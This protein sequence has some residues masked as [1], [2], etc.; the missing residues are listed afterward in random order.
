MAYAVRWQ[1]NFV[2]RN[3]DSYRL[4][5]LQD[6]WSGSITYLRGAEKPI[7]TSEDNSDDIFTPIRKQ[8]GALRIADNGFDIN[9]NAFDYTDLIPTDTFDNQVRL[10]L[11]GQTDTLRW[12]GY[13]RP[14]SLTSR[15][16]EYVSIREFQIVCPLGTLYEMPVSFS[17][18]KNDFGTIKT[19]GQ[20]LHAALS[21][22]GVAWGNVYK[23][24]NVQHR[25]DLIAKVSMLNFLSTN[26]PTHSTPSDVDTF[27]ATWQDESTSWGSVVEDVCRFWGWTLYSR[28][29][30]L[31][32][33]AQ[34]QAFKFAKFAFSNLT[35]TSNS[36]MS[37]ISDVD[38]SIDDLT[39][40]S[41]NHTESRK[42]GYKKIS[43]ESDVNEWSTVLDPDY[44]KATFSYYPNDSQVIHQS[45]DYM[46][47]LRRLGAAN[48]QQNTQTQFID[49]FQIYEN[50]VLQTSTL[51][52][53]FVIEYSDPMYNEDFPTKTAF[54]LKKG[55]VCYQGGQSGAITFFAKTLEDVIIPLNSAISINASAELSY[56]PDPTFPTNENFAAPYDEDDKPILEGRTIH[57]A[58]AIGDMWWDDAHQYW[59]GTPTAFSITMRK[60]GS[61]T[62]PLNT[63]QEGG[64]SPQGI[65]FDNHAGTSG[66]T[67][68][69]TPD[70]FT[71]NGLCGRLKLI[72]YATQGEPT[73]RLFNGVLNS[74][75]V[76]IYNQDNKLN[77][78]NK[79]SHTYDG[80]A[81]VN[82]RNSR[83]VSLKMASGAQNTY[84]KGQLYNG[85]FS[86]LTTVPFRS[87]GLYTSMS[88]EARLLQMMQDIYATVTEHDIIEIADNQNASLPIARMSGHWSGDDNFRPLCV[89]HDWVDGT[90]ELTIFNK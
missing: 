74:L 40:V 77:P 57:V 35:S 41:T 61:I 46:Y 50:R 10:W 2:A 6:G 49:N 20:I 4:E 19:M 12:V 28:G 43:V 86:L 87:G 44:K 72:I 75:T 8:T 37:D 78:I 9:G 7:E 38:V 68:Y 29:Y 30:D 53:D 14:D 42:Q 88:P 55:I 73:T 34:H 11:V 21:N 33:I 90:M 59:T 69:N 54:G 76:S 67:I 26:E 80:I 25:E 62:T 82:F 1:I 47:V 39:W 27:T 51:I 81:S 84:G 15:L 65:L 24:N 83:S 5:I 56:N 66:Y 60:D 32:I 85:N 52:A 89:A 63:F 48:A 64:F 70:A 31:F 16:F 18:T 22:V 3:Q 79:D 58:L 23:Q 71:G 17:N 45:N 13:I 36:S